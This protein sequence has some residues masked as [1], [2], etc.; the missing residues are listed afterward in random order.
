MRITKACNCNRVETELTKFYRIMP[1]LKNCHSAAG[2]HF[3]SHGCRL[4]NLID[5]PDCKF[6]TLDKTDLQKMKC[7]DCGKEYTFQQLQE[8]REAISKNYA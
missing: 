1:T 6:G 4:T 8:L 5:C 3:S 7:A 2:M